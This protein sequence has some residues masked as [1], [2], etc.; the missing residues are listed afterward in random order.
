MIQHSW[1]ERYKKRSYNWLQHILYFVFN[2]LSATFLLVGKDLLFILD[3]NLWPAWLF[4]S[5]H[6][7]LMTVPLILS[8]FRSLFIFC[9]LYSFLKCLFLKRSNPV[10]PI[11]S[12][13]LAFIRLHYS[14]CILGSLLYIYFWFL[15]ADDY[16][17]LHIVSFNVPGNLVALR[18]GVFDS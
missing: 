15:C 2:R 10:F 13:V 7:G 3:N 8:F 6:S 17:F 12:T 4:C 9:T 18:L 14:Y 16:L 1:F 11:S 5:V